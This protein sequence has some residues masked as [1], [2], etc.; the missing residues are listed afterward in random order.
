MVEN[1]ICIRVKE[2][3][4]EKKDSPLW[5]DK[6]WESVDD[7]KQ[8]FT[9]NEVNNKAVNNLN[10]KQSPFFQS[11]LLWFLLCLLLLLPIFL[12]PFIPSFIGLLACCGI[13]LII[14]VNVIFWI[15]DEDDSSR[16]ARKILLLIVVIACLTY[17]GWKVFEAN[18]CGFP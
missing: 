1:N 7:S 9:G 11:D 2:K 10:L 13:I 12:F 14:L 3:P 8:G 16:K 17:W 4:M 5:S 15:I 18:C 6:I